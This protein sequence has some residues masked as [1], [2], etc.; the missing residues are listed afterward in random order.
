M[1]IETGKIIEITG[2]R[3]DRPGFPKLGVRGVRVKKRVPCLRDKQR[4]E[5]HRQ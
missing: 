1:I 5:D 4:G 3:Y 2:A